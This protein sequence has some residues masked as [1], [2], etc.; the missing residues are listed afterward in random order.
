M[1][2][3]DLKRL[4]LDL[5]HVECDRYASARRAPGLNS[6]SSFLPVQAKQL[7]GKLRHR[8]ARLTDR[9]WYSTHTHRSPVSQHLTESQKRR[10]AWEIIWSNC[11]SAKETL[12]HSE[13][14]AQR[15]VGGSF[16]S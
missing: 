16:V 1:I 8:E 12:W 7:R 13:T 4:A 3:A 5:S 10:G 15:V 11:L 9:C 2:I 6:D 14:G